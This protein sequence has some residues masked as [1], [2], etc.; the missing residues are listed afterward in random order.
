MS[1]FLDKGG[2]VKPLP[3]RLMSEYGVYLTGP[4]HLYTDKQK[5]EL[6][7]QGVDTSHFTEITAADIEEPA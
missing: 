2:R 4:V 7:A 5:A 1:Q 3:V 6:E